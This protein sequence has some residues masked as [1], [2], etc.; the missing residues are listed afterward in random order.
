M[1]LIL[2]NVIYVELCCSSPG[3]LWQ[4]VPQL[5]IYIMDRDNS[6]FLMFVLRKAPQVFSFF[7]VHLCSSKLQ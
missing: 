6:F 5:H 4:F 3:S 1:I 7:C 2:D